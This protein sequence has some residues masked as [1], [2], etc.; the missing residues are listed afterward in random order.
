MAADQHP[1]REILEKAILGYLE[2]NNEISNLEQFG[3]Q[4]AAENK[5]EINH[6]DIDSAIKSLRGFGYVETHDIRKESWVLTEEGKGYAAA[7]SP[8]VQV[9]LAIP[10]EGITQVELKKKLEDSV[11]QRGFRHALKNEWVEISKQ[12]VTRKVQHLDDKVRELLMR[13]HA[14][15]A[16]DQAEIEALKERKLIQKQ[17]QKGYSPVKKGPNY[18]PVRKKFVTDLTRESLQ[19]GD[20]KELEFKEFNLNAQGMP[21]KFGALHP[22][23]KVRKQ[24]KDIFIQMGYEEMATN[25]YVESSFWNFDALFQPQ[26]HPA[27]DSHDTFFLRTPSTTKELPE[28]YVER[29][30]RVH[31]SGGYESRG[32]GCDWKREEAEK[33][34]LRTH[35]TAVSSRI[36]YLLAKEAQQRPFA[37]KKYFSID[38]VFR[39]E[40]VDRTHLAEFHQIEGWICDRG[41]TLGNLMGLLEDFF[42]RLGMSKLKFKPAYNPYTEPSMEIFGYHKGF[43]KWVEIG[44]SGMFRPEMLR[45][46]GFPEDVEV[47]AWG[48]SLERPA[49]ILYEIDNIREM[50]GHQVD[51]GFI[52]RNPICRLG[53][54]H[55]IE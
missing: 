1:R 10:A 9:F 24:V 25:N 15:E 19:N 6:N 52:K 41:L 16:V 30:K 12:L 31:E 45:P 13:I 18:A 49:M 36:L 29:V 4:L 53:L 21:S 5:S 28:D 44:N 14:N 20:W 35:T 42:K 26:Q 7:G 43:R 54:S 39:N 55:N 17:T 33:N 51:L 8:E 34:L 40:S 2:N 23:L 46:M 27:R 38:R 22:L 11:F 3:E 32:Y 48:L 37:P 47:I 50:F